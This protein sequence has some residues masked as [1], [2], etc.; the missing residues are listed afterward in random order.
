[1]STSKHEVQTLLR[2][3]AFVESPRWH[4]GRL[5]FSDWLTRVIIAVDL[6]GKSEVKYRLPT[7]PF[8]MDWLPD[9]RLLLTSGTV[10]LRGQPDGSLVPHADLT[11]LCKKGLNE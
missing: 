9:G 10:I 3:R 5:W 4:E 8:S 6:R 1:M 11:N 7:F 2:G